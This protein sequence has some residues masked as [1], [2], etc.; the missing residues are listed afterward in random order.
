MIC[1]YEECTGCGACIN[2]CPKKCIRLEPNE[3]G[4]EH[5]IIVEQ[6]CVQCG[7]CKRVCPNNN[8]LNRK[9]P[10][11]V[12][13]AWTA[14]VEERKNSASGGIGAVLADWCICN[15]G[16]A[17][18]V[19]YDNDFTPVFCG[20]ADRNEI[21][22]FKG[23]KYVQAS[24]GKIFS[25][26]KKKLNDR[27]TPIV[28]FGTPCQIA[29]LY[30]VVG[31]KHE[32]LFTVELLCHG[33]SPVAYF[34]EELNYIRQSK[35]V[36]S[37]DNVTF[38]T[39]QYLLD[40]NFVL[41]KN[42]RTVFVQDSHTNEYFESF[43]TGLSLRESCYDCKYK[44]LDRVADV[45]IGDFIGLG[46]HVPFEGESERKSLILVNTDKGIKLINECAGKLVLRERTL[47]EA[48]IEGTSLKQSFPR[49]QQQKKF[50]DLYKN[51]GFIYAV[52]ATIGSDIENNAK[53][54]KKIIFK[55]RL[56]RFL[57]SRFHIII[58]NGKIHY[59]V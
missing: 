53:N 5:P 19:A 45:T 7:A 55:K 49:H 8:I 44:N 28:F 41:W 31:S 42:G 54:R 20:I 27:N 30:S 56:K 23:S 11:K 38:R 50:R 46:K 16:I 35:R 40:F 25:D 6:E 34:H 24:T 9:K 39:N 59:E 2:V 48:L 22:K 18:G 29:G 51:K 1:V 47:E 32:N 15:G 12:Y 26:V 14:N 36:K 10:I 21:E 52:N 13:A 37:F 3:Y 57:Q 17:Y 4:E 33:V 43:L 58:E